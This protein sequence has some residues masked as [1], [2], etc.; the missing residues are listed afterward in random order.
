MRF[1]FII[2]FKNLTGFECIFDGDCNSVFMDSVE[3]QYCVKNKC[4]NILAPMTPC[5]KPQECSSYSY[6][7]PLACSAKCDTKQE[8]GNIYHEKT[9]YCCKP[10]PLGGTCNPTKPRSINGC[11]KNQVCLS[12]NGISKCAEITDNSWVLGSFLS[13]GGN[14]LINLGI[15]FQKLSY[16]KE[17][18]LI[19]NF[20][21]KTI[22]L[23][24][25][26][27]ILGKITSYS[28]YIF[29]NQSFLAGL[30]A[31]GLISNSII[32]PIINNEIFTWNDGMAIFL[33]IIGSLILF[34]STSKTHN[35]YTICE[36]MKMLKQWRNITWLSFI[37]FIIVLLFFTIKFIEI[38]SPWEFPNDMFHFLKN[39]AYNFEEGGIVLKYFMVVFYVCLSSFIASFTTLSIKIIGEIFNRYFT[40]DGSIFNFT[41]LF[42][43]MTLFICTF[44]QIY[45]INRAFK[46]FDALIVIP[47]FHLT[48]SILSILTAGIYF[49]DFSSY[50]NLQIKKFIIGVGIIF[51]GSIFLGLKI[52]NKNVLRSERN[53]E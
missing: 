48:W 46:H 31:S 43:T 5:N 34:H 47:I 19:Q 51:C 10:I 26:I 30:S 9:T 2:F 14:I 29:C 39:D 18:I 44:G 11:A 22:Y 37:F 7:G 3:K 28:A 1:I 4:T 12:E 49:Q 15:N 52:K 16:K 40:S 42:F 41:T 24:T 6:Y 20:N 23:G 8:C 45:W 50:S 27:Y 36:L 38:N 17:N 35:V 53:D 21:L 33:V 32:A 13:I 25:F